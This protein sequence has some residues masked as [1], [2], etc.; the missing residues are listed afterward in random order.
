VFA[1]DTRTCRTVVHRADE[2]FPSCSVAKTVA[3]VAVLRD[4]DRGGEF[5]TRR[6]RY[7][8]A[9]VARAGYAPITGEPENLA[10]GMTVEALCAAAIAYSDNAAMNLLLRQLGGPTAVTRFC[11]SIGDTTT[12]LDRWEP[13]LNSAEPRRV[14]DTTSPRPGLPAGW[15][16]DREGPA[17]APTAPRTTSASPGHPTGRRSCSPCWPG[18]A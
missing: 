15:R 12:R 5:R 14:S 1:L 3:A 4:L 7:T 16:G 11:R 6:I 10:N 8:E 17:A 9:D 18:R 13:D 2:R